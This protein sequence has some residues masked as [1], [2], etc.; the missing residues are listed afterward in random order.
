MAKQTIRFY[1]IPGIEQVQLVHG[2][3]VR[4]HFPRHIHHSASFGIVTRG[5]RVLEIRRQSVTIATG[6][7]FIL[8]PGDPHACAADTAQSHDYWVLSLPPEL[9]QAILADLT[10]QL[11][12][13]P[14]FPQPVIRDPAFFQLMTAFVAEVQYAEDGLPQEALFLEVITHCLQHYAQIA[15]V[16][17]EPGAHTQLVAV[18][19]QY[20]ADH[21]ADHITLADLA[22]IAHASPYYLTRLFQ[23]EVGLPPYEYLVQLRIKH[24]QT[25][26]KTG[27]ALADAAYRTSFADQSH[28]TRFFKRHVGLTPGEYLRAQ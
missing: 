16:P 28:F 3:D 25:L 24:A 15:Y 10:G 19:R 18:V 1:T 21:L 27:A 4:H 26:L 17:R 11:K 13:G 5:A 7:G 14:Y 20:L 2:V 23:R 22:K 8:N 6:A 12:P 9:L